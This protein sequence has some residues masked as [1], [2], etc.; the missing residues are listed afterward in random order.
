MY[1][2]SNAYCS[3]IAISGVESPGPLGVPQVTLDNVLQIYHQWL[4]AHALYSVPTPLPSCLLQEKL[5][6]FVMSLPVYLLA[7]EHMIAAILVSCEYTWPQLN[8]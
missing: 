3:T 4:C 5:C 6:L 8:V 1:L 7:Q 2:P